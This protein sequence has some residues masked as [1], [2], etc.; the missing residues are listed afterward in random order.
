MPKVVHTVGSFDDCDEGCC[1]GVLPD[2][3]R[4]EEVVLFVDLLVDMVELVVKD[5][6]VGASDDVDNVVVGD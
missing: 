5:E 6:V 3:L 2:E 4:E 1:D